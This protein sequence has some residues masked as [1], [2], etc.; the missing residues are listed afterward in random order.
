VIAAD[1]DRPFIDAKQQK[2]FERVV[3]IYLGGKMVQRK[4]SSRC[5]R[6]GDWDISAG[7]L[8]YRSSCN[9]PFWH[10]AHHMVPNGALHAA[11]E[12]VGSDLPQ[13]AE[14]TLK[15]RDG[16]LEA[17]Y[18]VNH[19]INMIILPI[20]KRI[21]EAILLP[22]HVDRLGGSNVRHTSYSDYVQQ[23]LD[24]V[25]EK[26]ASKV[27]PAKHEVPNLED[28]KTKLE[29]LSNTLRKEIKATG[30]AGPGTSLDE[31]FAPA[32]SDPGESLGG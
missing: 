16:L 15:I 29:D 11:V 1:D 13:H 6:N 4:I 24:K 31:S 2:R 19:K 26:V 10:E 5:P 9:R 7:G 14:I 28:S 23:K 27:D 25:F 8:N 22:M 20:E 17:I 30:R 21:A 18:N 12:A 32:P 3:L